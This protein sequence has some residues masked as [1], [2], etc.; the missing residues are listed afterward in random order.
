MNPWIL[1]AGAAACCAALTAEAGGTAPAPSSNIPTRRPT[2]PEDAPMTITERR[3]G[4][5]SPGLSEAERATLFALARDTLAWCVQSGR[6]AFP[7]D[8]YTLTPKLKEPAATFVTLKR[9]GELRGC[10]GC[11]AAEEALYLSV[12][13]NAV[14]AALRDF[15]FDP[16]RPDEVPGL[17]LDVSILSPA[18]AIPDASAFTP[19]THGI[20][21]IKGSTRAVFLPEVAVEQ[22][23]TRED[24]LSHLS[25]KAGL[26]ADAWRQGA[27][28]EVFES[29]VLSAAE[30][31]PKRRP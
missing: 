30:P 25:R 29:V 19:G 5:W 1:A 18:R 26:P 20:I 21:L 17:S 4:T 2:H 24:T 8:R 15:R 6:G 28:F 13:H 16:V 14:N 12:H 11:L 9:G 22:G 27:R 23:W 31:A 3:S 7:M 10:I